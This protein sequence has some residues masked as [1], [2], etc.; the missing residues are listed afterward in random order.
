MN[1]QN[2]VPRN[3]GLAFTNLRIIL[4]IVCDQKTHFM[5]GT[6]GGTMPGFSGTTQLQVGGI[7]LRSGVP[8]P[9]GTGGMK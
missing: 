6:V 4:I 3:N 9:Q 8:R 2:A 1:P 7:L 5:L